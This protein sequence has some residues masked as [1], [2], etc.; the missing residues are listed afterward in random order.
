MLLITMLTA[1][2]LF[3]VT[4]DDI[5]SDGIR[6][7]DQA[8]WQQAEEIFTRFLATWPDHELK[9]KA[10]YYKATASTRN[11]DNSINSLL[12]DKAEIWKEDLSNLE[13]DLPAE[14][15]R[16]LHTAIEIA[17]QCNTAP[18]WSAL[19]E[20]SPIDLKHYLQRSWHPDPTLDPMATLAW[21]NK[22]LKNH[23]SHLDPDLE[24]RMELLRARA[25]WQVLL[26]PLSLH[27]NSD[28][29][30]VWE[31]WPV[32]NRLEKSLKRGFATGNAEIKRKIALLGYHF[33]YFRDRRST[34]TSAINP[35]SQWYSYLSQRGINLQEAWCPR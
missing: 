1:S 27:A 12:A 6:A 2:S 26:S 29:L 5:F 7:F 23:T 22:W 34:D 14:D 9:T 32:Q 21:S 35:K 4:A 19:S 28:I 20:A 25:L 13:K 18:S 24:S 11:L 16:E 30:K 3:A 10:L 15:L 31:C 8:R 17:N 33:D